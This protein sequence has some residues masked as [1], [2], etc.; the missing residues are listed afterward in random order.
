MITVAETATFARRADKLFSAHEKAELVDFL[1]LNPEAGDIVPGLGGIRKVRV[2]MTGRGKRGGARVIY[3]FHSEV[4]PLIALLVYAKN[5]RS[6]LTTEQK[7]DISRL[8]EALKPR[9][10]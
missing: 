5:E 7:K 6:D 4:M 9:S 8:V 10:E 2:P 3:Y 1:S